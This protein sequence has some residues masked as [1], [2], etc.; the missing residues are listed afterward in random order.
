LAEKRADEMSGSRPK[1]T[2]DDPKDNSRFWAV[3]WRV[4]DLTKLATADHRPISSLSSYTKGY[5]REN[6]PPRGPEIVSR[7][8]W[9]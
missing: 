9:I 1:T 2:V 3:F 7:P 4:T 5:W 8:S 6:S